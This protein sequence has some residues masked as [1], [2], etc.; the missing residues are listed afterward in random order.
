ME[1]AFGV[2][3]PRKKAQRDELLR[4]Y[5]CALTVES[6][7]EK[8]KLILGEVNRLQSGRECSPM[9][10]AAADF[11]KIPRSLRQLLRILKNDKKS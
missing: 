1:L 9:V 2:S 5:A 3:P 8:A 7:T 4:Q 10:A 11:K 6:N